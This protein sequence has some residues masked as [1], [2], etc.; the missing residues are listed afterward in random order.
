[1]KYRL[2]F[3]FLTFSKIS[4]FI[5]IFLFPAVFFGGGNDSDFYD[6]Y[7]LGE[8]SEIPNIWPVI[9]RIL[10]EH[11]LYSR[12]GV[13]FFLAFLGILVIPLLVGKLASIKNSPVHQRVF[14][15]AA[16]FMAAYPTLFFYTF[17]IYR[18][19]FM[20]FLFVLGLMS[21][22]KFTA[23]ADIAEKIWHTLLITLISYFLYLFRPYL[24]FGFFISFI[25][26]SY[27]QFKKISLSFLLASLIAALNILFLL[28]LLQPI[29]AYRGNFDDMDGGSNIGIRFDSIA[30]FI[31][32]FIKSFLYQIFGLYFPNYFSIV[33]FLVES[34]PF[35]FMF[36]YLIKN[37]R[38]SNAFVNY[39][40]VFFISYSTIWLLGNDNL[41]TAVRLRLYSYI[42]ILLACA[43]IYQRKLAFYSLVKKSHFKKKLAGTAIRDGNDHGPALPT[44]D[45]HRP[46]PSQP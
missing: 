16:I 41:G 42:S 26:F 18:D 35:I 12:K 22:R 25:G 43:I 15:I 11:G 38:H 24:G 31:P 3:A 29:F 30:I 10:N 46:S 5:Y 17:D 9:L 28:G 19:V 27:F 20:V 2:L 23:S 45:S 32:D 1:M 8:D 7:A 4:I 40:V 6:S 21:V 36:F 37:R 14:W 34:L 44:S 39:L 33:V 13:S